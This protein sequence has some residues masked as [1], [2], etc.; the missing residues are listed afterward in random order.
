MAFFFLIVNLSS[1]LNNYI[2]TFW[3][4]YA[5]L[6]SICLIGIFILTIGIFLPNKATLIKFLNIVTSFYL[7]IFFY[8]ASW[9]YIYNITEINYLF[10]QNYNYYI[11]IFFFVTTITVLIFFLSISNIYFLEENYKMEYTFLIF[12]IYLSALFLMSTLDFISIIILL[13]CIA[14]SS[15]ILVGFERKNK[16]SVAAGVKYLI[17]AAIPAGLFILGISLLYNNFGTI[18]QDHLS[19]LIASFEDNSTFKSIYNEIEAILLF[20]SKVYSINTTFDQNLNWIIADSG[21]NIKYPFKGNW[22]IYFKQLNLLL[23][24]AIFYLEKLAENITPFQYLE[25]DFFYRLLLNN[26][27]DLSLETRSYIE[28]CYKTRFFAFV[29]LIQELKRAHELWIFV[30]D[31]CFLPESE[32]CVSEYKKNELFL[33]F[34]EV[35]NKNA[36]YTGI[37]SGLSFWIQFISYIQYKQELCLNP[38]PTD[39][40]MRNIYFIAQFQ[41]G[42]YLRLDK[43]HFPPAFK[44]AITHSFAEQSMTYNLFQSWNYFKMFSSLKD[45]ALKLQNVYFWIYES[46]YSKKTELNL[47]EASNTW[48]GL[49]RAKMFADCESGDCETKIYKIWI[50]F[51][52]TNS[53]WFPPNK[54]PA[55]WRSIPTELNMHDDGKLLYLLKNIILPELSKNSLNTITNIFKLNSHN[56]FLST[57][58][59]VIFILINLCFKITAAPFHFW[60][61]SIYGNSPLPT[62]AFLSV[63]SKLTIIFFFFYLFTTVFENLI[64]IW[65]PILFF[66]GVLSVII[67]ILGASSEKIFKRFFVYSS[68]GHVGFMVLGLSTGNLNGILAGVDYL[69]LYIIS[70][71][72]C[73]FILMHLKKTT[74]HLNN[75]KSLAFNSPILSAVLVITLFSISGLPPMGGFFVKYAIFLSLLESSQYFLAGFLFVLTVFSFFYYLRFIKIIYFEDN[76][77]I[78]KNKN[79]GDIKLNVI[80]ILFFLVCLYIFVFE[81][82]YFIIIKEFM[83]KSIK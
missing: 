77:Q 67:S 68:I 70:S 18:S 71:F 1:N 24:E 13:E 14:F 15:Y 74:T 39:L 10:Q 64:F 54:Y 42:N 5:N 76:K 58:L 78:K 36:K 63:F 11:N 17:L 66:L 30:Y 52:P 81:T 21:H 28:N 51:F 44:A 38:G 49:R 6:I 7:L 37:Y 9:E 46:L 12:Y 4:I 41:E 73:W 33:I 20:I 23:S 34:I 16:F 26:D 2:D 45:S 80:S 50:D 48:F 25:L 8:L 69:I 43:L 27:V 22:L 72:I 82:S 55:L 75:F 35:L 65:Q 56:I 19:I 47:Q 57:Y 40:L 32:Y 3:I 61:P 60:A 83:I 29:I 62:I 59:I 79:L 31:I 53:F